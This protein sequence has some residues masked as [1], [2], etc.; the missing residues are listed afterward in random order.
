MAKEVRKV[1]FGKGVEKS[2]FC[3]K[4]GEESIFFGKRIRFFKIFSIYIP[5]KPD[6]L[7]NCSMAAFIF[8]KEYH[9]F[10]NKFVSRCNH[11][12]IKS[13]GVTLNFVSIYFLILGA[14][15]TQLIAFSSACTISLGPAL[16]VFRCLTGIFL[17]V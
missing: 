4:R 15:Q 17:G 16:V 12:C 6:T 13:F 9:P 10:H 7:Q 3:G 14:A 8:K 5:Y 2:L 1:L 11:S